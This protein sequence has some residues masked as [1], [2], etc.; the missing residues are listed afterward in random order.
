MHHSPP[1][2]RR[3]RQLNTG[4]PTGRSGARVINVLQGEFRMSGEPD[5]MMTTLLGSCVAACL[6]DPDA[7]VGGMN[8][9]LLP[10][11]EAEKG[12][13]LRYGVNAMEL[14][15]NGLIKLGA[16]RR[17]I[18]AKLFGGAKMSRS[19]NDIGQRNIAFAKWYMENE[20]FPVEIACMGGFRGRKLRF[21]PTTGR[22]QRMFMQSAAQLNAVELDTSRVSRATRIEESH[23]GDVE[24]F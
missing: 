16:D 9:F 24:L 19:G 15:L 23:D 10:G 5:V 18:H 2:L 21:W 7:A 17:R 1:D 6:Y 13:H 11:S 14:L 22:A 8:H 3:A 12:G 20:G 4:T